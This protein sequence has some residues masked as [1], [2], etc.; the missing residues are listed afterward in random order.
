MGLPGCVLIACCVFCL[1]SPLLWTN[2][3]VWVDVARAF[4][5][6]S[7]L[8]R[9]HLDPH[10]NLSSFSGFLVC[11]RFPNQ[12]HHC[13]LQFLVVSTRSRS[14]TA[15]LCALRFDGRWRSRGAGHGLPILRW[16]GRPP[17]ETKGL[18]IS[19]NSIQLSEES[20]LSQ[21]LFLVIGVALYQPRRTNKPFNDA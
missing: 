7:K 18:I 13:P 4:S 20:A 5:L 6:E 1:Q 8:G 2:T 21:V 12:A 16:L 19:A 10:L 14:S 17:F 15:F 3:C 9:F 11:G